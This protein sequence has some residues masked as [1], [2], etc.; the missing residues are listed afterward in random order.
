MQEILPT[1]SFDV[2]LG[3]VP[4]LD[5]VSSDVFSDETFYFNSDVSPRHPRLL[6][7]INQAQVVLVYV[8]KVFDTD[9]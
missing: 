5:E 1:V 4:V 7:R 6:Q 8:Y 9:I 3:E 2:T